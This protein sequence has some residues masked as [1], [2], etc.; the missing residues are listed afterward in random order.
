MNQHTIYSALQGRNNY[1]PVCF[2]AM[3]KILTLII[4]LFA[5][6]HAAQAQTDTTAVK[7]R[8]ASSSNISLGFGFSYSMLTLRSSPFVLV[9]STGE[10]GNSRVKNSL[11]ANVS[12]CYNIELGERFLLR[13]GIDAHFMRASILY[14]TRLDNKKRGEVFPVAVEIPITA[15]YK[16]PSGTS[17]IDLLL[18]IRPV[19]AVKQFRSLYPTLKDGN[20]N[21]DAGIGIPVKMKKLNC[22]VEAIYSYGLMNLIGKNDKDFYTNSVSYLGRSYAGLRLYF[23]S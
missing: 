15:M 6:L 9:D 18:G 10:M 12:L 16:I 22:H 5:L 11:G 19:I 17:S 2:I 1:V 3:K 14:D 20:L 23:S 13:P 21:I 7:K 4:S 8:S